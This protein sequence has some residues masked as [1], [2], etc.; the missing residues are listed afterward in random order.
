M[1]NP[2]TGRRD[3]SPV[4]PT[5]AAETGATSAA[6][7][8]LS[9]YARSVAPPAFRAKPGVSTVAD[10][11]ST[12]DAAP[13]SSSAAV[14]LPSRPSIAPPTTAAETGA[15][16]DALAT[17]SSYAR[18]AAL[19]A[20]RVEPGASMVAVSGLTT[21]AAPTSP[22]VA[23]A[24][25]AFAPHNLRPD[26][27]SPAPPTTAAETGVTSAV[28]A[29]SASADRSAAQPASRTGPGVSIAA[30]SGSTRA[31]VPNSS[32]ANPPT[33]QEPL[34]SKWLLFRLTPPQTFGEKSVSVIN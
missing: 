28:V 16:S 26:K 5:T 1:H 18:S 9:S 6:L 14:G 25:V 31:A 10:S 30:A 7:A 21:D 15:T 19:P 12:M 34:P 29:T 32:S 8:T 27:S 20:F 4:R 13:S 24:A 22:S 2:A 11:G 23:E 33:K 3:A 17:L